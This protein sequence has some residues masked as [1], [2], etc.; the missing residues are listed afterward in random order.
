MKRHLLRALAP[1]GSTAAALLV[2]ACD[3]GVPDA[4]DE[5]PLDVQSDPGA[6]V[7]GDAPPAP[8]GI[9]RPRGGR[10]WPLVFVDGVEV[11]AGTLALDT[12]DPDDIDRIEVIKGEA[13]TDR[14]GDRAEGGVIL[15]FT[16]IAQPAQPEKPLTDEEETGGPGFD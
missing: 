6:A 14:F 12:L 4:V 16:R 8:L 10:P 11:G 15:I 2:I 13:A 3:P 5:A 9:P 1:A 7:A